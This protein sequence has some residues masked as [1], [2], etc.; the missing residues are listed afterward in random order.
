[1]RTLLTSLLAV[2]LANT[3]AAQTPSIRDGA[4]ADWTRLKDTMMKIADAMPEEKFGFRATPPERTFGEQIL[5]VAE[6][7]VVQMGRFASK[8]TPP[9][10]NMK[11]TSKT[12]I[13][14]ALGDSFDF[15]TAALNE[16]TDQTMLLTA[17]TTR[18][19]RFMGPSTKAR[20]VYYV[21]GHTWD[22]YGQMVVY[23]RL[24]GLTP[25]ASQRF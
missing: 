14:K 2:L 25:P 7:N 5:H 23:L 24:N 4:L 8:A 17:E 20:V 11:A 13:L 10:V 22:I 18:Y 19:D 21:I 1:M 12:E 16:Q 6:A 9:V 15:G 3:A